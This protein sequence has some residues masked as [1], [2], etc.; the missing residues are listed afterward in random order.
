MMAIPF[1]AIWGTMHGRGPF[2]MQSRADKCAR[3]SD[4]S[5]VHGNSAYVFDN[6]YGGAKTLEAAMRESEVIPP[7]GREARSVRHFRVFLLL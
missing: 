5:P 2:L 4:V 1:P 7:S 3:V 6:H